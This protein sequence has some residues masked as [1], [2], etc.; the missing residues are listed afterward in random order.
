MSRIPPVAI[1]ILLIVLCSIMPR[2]SHANV[3]PCE[4]WSCPCEG[5]SMPAWV[6]VSPKNMVV[7]PSA[8]YS[9][10]FRLI[11]P[12]NCQ[13]VVDFP[14]SQVELRFTLCGEA[15]T[16][17]T[18]EIMADTH[19][20]GEGRIFW[21]ASLAFGGS[22]PCSVDVLVQNAVF[23]TIA[24]VD[25]DLNGGVRSPDEN[26]DGVV[27]LTDLVI[28]RSS[29]VTGNPRYHGDLGPEFDNTTSLS[30]LQTWQLHFVAP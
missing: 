24:G 21:D 30:D 27:S 1:L 4:C 16:R 25:Q 28:W 20:D 7:P 9:Y 5:Y 3:E 26:G 6:G 10:C 19:S 18:N 2:A 23:W 13:P 11:N 17:P 15:S 8:R 29:F 12:D 22:D 14:P